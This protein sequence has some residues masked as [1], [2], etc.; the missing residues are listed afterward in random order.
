LLDAVRYG[1]HVTPAA[2]IE[3]ELMQLYHCGPWDLARVEMVQAAR[4][5]FTARMLDEIR[6]L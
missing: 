2:V 1:R 4:H 5:L 3:L 6:R